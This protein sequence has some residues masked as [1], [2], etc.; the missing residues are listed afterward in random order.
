[1][2]YERLTESFR[3]GNCHS[4]LQPPGEPLEL[5][6]E[7]VF[8]ALVS[9]STLPVLADFWAVWCGP[10]KMMAPELAKVAIDLRGQWIV[11]KVDTD[12]AP[13]LSQRFQISGI[14]TLIVFQSGREVG[15]KS[16]AMPAAA[17]RQF[18]QPYHVAGA[19]RENFR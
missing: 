2:A 12:T 14:P 7:A 9:R 19:T 15:R 18:L 5:G 6:D 1:M 4:E 10:C 3:C 13:D 8:N 16:G 17:I 11:A